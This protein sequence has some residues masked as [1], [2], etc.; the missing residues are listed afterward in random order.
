MYG[1]ASTCTVFEP[2]EKIVLK[3]KVTLNVTNKE[4][5]AL[6]S[7][8]KLKANLMFAVCTLERWGRLKLL[9]RALRLR[10]GSIW[11]GVDRKSQD[12]DILK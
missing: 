3:G 9:D 4:Y 10:M 11:L 5:A 1:D 2:D 12:R 8:E 7:A 6:G